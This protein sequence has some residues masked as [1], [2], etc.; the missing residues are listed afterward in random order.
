MTATHLHGSA[1]VRLSGFGEYQ[2]AYTADSEGGKESCRY[3]YI[4]PAD[5]A[6][7]FRAA[8]GTIDGESEVS[9]RR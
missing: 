1:P 6:E 2:T 3:E 9:W 7:A 8:G 4:I 5:K